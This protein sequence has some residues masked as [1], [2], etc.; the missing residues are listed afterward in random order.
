ME[1]GQ[2]GGVRREILLQSV[3][4]NVSVEIGGDGEEKIEVDPAL[5]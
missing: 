3:R 5:L 2:W 1:R 4:I